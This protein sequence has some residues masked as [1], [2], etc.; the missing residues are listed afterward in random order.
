MTS[1]LDELLKKL[2]ISQS[3]SKSSAKSVILSKNLY[4]ECLDVEARRKLDFALLQRELIDIFGFEWPASN[5]TKLANEAVKEVL[6]RFIQIEKSPLVDLF[7]DRD[8]NDTLQA[9]FYFNVPEGFDRDQII[10]LD[11]ERYA[12]QI[13][14]YLSEMYDLTKQIVSKEAPGTEEEVTVLEI[15]SGIWELEKALVNASTP[16]EKLSDPR[17]SYNKMSLKEFED[18]TGNDFDWSS[19]V[20]LFVKQFNLPVKVTKETKVIV[21]DV[22]YFKKLPKILSETPLYILYNYLGMNLL[23]SFRN[24]SDT[25]I[26]EQCLSVV[27][28][29]FDQAVSRMYVDEYVPENTKQLAAKFIADIQASFRH[30]I[31]KEATWLDEKTKSKVL[32]KESAT[33]FDIVYPDWILNDNLLDD[34]YGLNDERVN[35]QVKKGHFMETMLDI[36]RHRMVTFSRKMDYIYRE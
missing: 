32:A 20:K 2:L 35:L 13:G 15:V 27:T 12:Q 34:H 21:D 8:I 7:I 26:E 5:E 22:E 9:I 17:D 24:Q 10:Y 11:Q 3:P 1:E 29:M 25:S 28:S 16:M 6:V 31:E 30:V 23:Y 4:K 36:R 33:K 14:Y 18:L 19:L